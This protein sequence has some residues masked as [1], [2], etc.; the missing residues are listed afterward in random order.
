MSPVCGFFLSLGGFNVAYLIPHGK[1][2]I[3]GAAA[4]DLVPTSEVP[5]PAAATNAALFVTNALRDA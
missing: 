1:V 2:N 4:A 3:S 5:I